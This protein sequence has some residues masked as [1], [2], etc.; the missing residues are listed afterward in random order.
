MEDLAFNKNSNMLH[1]GEEAYILKTIREDMFNITFFS[2]LPWLLSLWKQ[3]PF[4]NRNYLK[5]RDWIQAQID[6]RIKV[7]S[8]DQQDPWSPLEQCS[9]RKFLRIH[10]IGQT[11]FPLF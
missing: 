10:Q 6:G 4:L 5:F 2:R 8:N 9:D 1:N 11:F 7:L 3:T